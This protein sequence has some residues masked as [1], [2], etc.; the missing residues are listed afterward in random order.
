MRAWVLDD[1]RTEAYLA[2]RFASA[3]MPTDAEI[4]TAY[5]RARAE[6]DNSGSTFEQATPLL[7]ERLITARRAEL[8]N[9]WL[10]DLRR[11]TDVVILQQ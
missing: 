11:R 7:R 2:Q 1:L 6:F 4:T 8:I 5:T 10:S 3:S 9:D